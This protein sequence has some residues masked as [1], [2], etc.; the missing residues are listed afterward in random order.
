MTDDTLQRGI[1]GMSRCLT[2]PVEL[3]FSNPKDGFICINGK[4][5]FD[6][7]KLFLVTRP[8]FIASGRDLHVCICLQGMVVSLLESSPET[9]SD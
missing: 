4:I 5:S 1:C 6:F 8:D 7:C 3:N 2:L 9:P